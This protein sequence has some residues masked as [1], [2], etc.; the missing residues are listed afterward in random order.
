MVTDV[1][2]DPDSETET[3]KGTKRV[4][5][6]KPI[7]KDEVLPYK[8]KK[9]DQRKRWTAEEET[10]IAA[11]FKNNFIEKRNPSAGEIKSLYEKYPIMKERSVAV[12]RVKINN[13]ILGKCK[14]KVN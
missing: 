7:D 6:P 5:Q 8:Q 4:L 2:S 3:E 10:I 14:T 13:I 11:E 1:E 12:V 9:F